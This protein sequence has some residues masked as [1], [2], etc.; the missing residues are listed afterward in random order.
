MAIV[1][2]ALDAGVNFFDTADVYGDRNGLSEI[3]L[4]RA[5]AGRR[6]KAVIATK[7]GME[8]GGDTD[9]GGASPRWVRQACDDSLRRLDVDHIDLYQLHTPDP[10]TPIE[11]TVGALEELVVQGKVREIGHSNLTGDQIDDAAA[12][13]RFVSAQFS[14]SLLARGVE[15]DG[16]LD[17]VRRNGLV[18]LPYYP[19][20]A[21]LLTGKY[22]DP[23]ATTG[24][25]RLLQNPVSGGR[26]MFDEALVAHVEK[27]AAFAESRQRTLLELAFGWLLSHDDIASVIAGVTRP[28]QLEANVAA[29]SWRLTDDERDEIDRI[30]HEA[31]A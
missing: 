14:W 6:D 24:Q 23:G 27:L 12:A 25:E 16:V 26:D 15:R 2:Q 17:A 8:M 3:L 11:E 20:A 18:V 29:S 5:L 31:A 10:H 21:G 30:A 28:Q 7:F 13:G 22:R 4:G 1:D 19:L 9:R